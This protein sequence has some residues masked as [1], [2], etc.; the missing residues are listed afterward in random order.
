[1]SPDE[2]FKLERHVDT[3]SDWR[4]APALVFRMDAVAMREIEAA[5]DRPARRRPELA[6]LFARPRPE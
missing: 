2:P 6:T 5:L 1:M 3:R 4:D